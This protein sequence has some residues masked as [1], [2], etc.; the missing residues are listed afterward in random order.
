MS[1]HGDVLPQWMRPLLIQRGSDKCRGRSRM[2]LEREDPAGTLP[3]SA[4][5]RS[6]ASADLSKISIAE[7]AD[8]FNP[9]FGRLDENGEPLPSVLS[10]RL[11]QAQ[12][13]AIYG[14]FSKE[15]GKK[16]IT[17]FAGANPSTMLH[18]MGHMFLDDLNDLAAFDEASAKDLATVNEWAEWHEGAA[19]EYADTPWAQEFREH[20]KAIRAALKSG[21]AIALRAARNRWRHERFARGFELYLY[22]GKA[23][24]KALRG[25]F[26]RFKQLLRRIYQFVK[27]VGGKP[28][29]EVE[30]V[31]A[32]MIA[33]EEEIKAAELDERWRPV[34]KMGGKEALDDLLGDDV[35][36]T[37]AKWLEEA[38]EDA[39]DIL[40]ARVMKDLKK[41]ARKEFKARVEAE[42]ERKRVQLENEPVYLAEAAIRAQG[43]E[44][45][46]LLFFPSV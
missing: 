17:L 24:S 38:R 19:K 20:E 21:D 34:E 28:S 26:R 8:Q 12:Q 16:I 13:R 23:P 44:R 46:A 14:E 4:V 43:D 15:N 42:R 3:R 33:S 22:E 2:M 30:A 39:E 25:V 11:A 9:L 18:E 45:A 1:T 32:R 29:P 5:K 37:Y 31:M 10:S 36:D 40:R 27:D 6:S 35:A 41:E 7:L